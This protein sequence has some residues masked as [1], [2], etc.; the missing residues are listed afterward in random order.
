MGKDMSRICLPV[1]FNEPLSS[2]QRAC[3]DLE[4]SSLLDQAAECTDDPILRA[5][6]VASFAVSGCHESEANWL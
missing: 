3:E 1:S 4:Y 2:L 6:L 5:A